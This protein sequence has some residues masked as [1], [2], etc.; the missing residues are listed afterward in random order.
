MTWKFI[1][2]GSSVFINK[3]RQLSF[4]LTREFLKSLTMKL[5]LAGSLSQKLTNKLKADKRVF[6]KVADDESM[7]SRVTFIVCTFKRDRR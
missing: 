7:F 1:G 2:T 5:Y 6:V 3:G 4:E